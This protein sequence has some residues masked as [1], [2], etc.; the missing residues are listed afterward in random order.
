MALNFGITLQTM[1][2]RTSSTSRR[3]VQFYCRFYGGE[4]ATLD[5]DPAWQRLDMLMT[6]P[7][8]FAVRLYTRVFFG[9]RGLVGRDVLL[10][11]D[12]DAG[13]FTDACTEEVAAC[14]HWFFG[15]AGEVLLA[16]SGSYPRI[17]LAVE[18]CSIVLRSCSLAADADYFLPCVGEDLDCCFRGLP[19]DAHSSH[20]RYILMVG[21]CSY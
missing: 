5:A 4:L 9:L 8:G 2:R 18:V 10:D 3:Y 20:S 16:V 15:W 1:E 12:V 7:S 17:L 6:F 19:A 14:A 13:G 21:S 11:D